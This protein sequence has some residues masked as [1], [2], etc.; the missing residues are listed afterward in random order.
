MNRHWFKNGTP[1]NGVK[2]R[3][4]TK[5]LTAQSLT[6]LPGFKRHSTQKQEK[7]KNLKTFSSVLRRFLLPSLKIKKIFQT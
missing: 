4:L 2:T 3:D 7:I 1:Q 6:E 5:R